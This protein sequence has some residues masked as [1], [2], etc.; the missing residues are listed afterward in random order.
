MAFRAWMASCRRP[1]VHAADFASS[2]SDL[3]GGIWQQINCGKADA[4]LADGDLCHARSITTPLAHTLE[5]MIP[6][7]WKQWLLRQEVCFQQG[8]M[9]ES[10]Q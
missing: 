1:G 8:V 9:K 7:A 10:P 3:G 2:V 6:D 4:A 5:N